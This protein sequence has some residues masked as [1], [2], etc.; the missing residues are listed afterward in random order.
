M[1]VPRLSR[2]TYTVRRIMQL[3]GHEAAKIAY[4]GH[5][6]SA[7][8]FGILFWGDSP[9]CI[10][11]F[12]KQK[13]AI[14]VLCG[15]NGRQ[16]CRELFPKE[17]ILTL[18]GIFIMA[19]VIYVYDHKEILRKN[20]CHHEYETRTR[21]YFTIPYHRKTCAEIDLKINDKE[22][23]KDNV[24]SLLR[25]LEDKGDRLF[26][27]DENIRGII[28]TDGAKDE[29]L[30]EEFD[31]VEFYREE[32]IRQ[33]SKYEVML[34]KIP[35]D[36]AASQEWGS[37]KPKRKFRLPKIELKKFDGNVKNWIGFGGQ[38]RKIHEDKEIDLEDKFQ[39]LLQATEV[40]SGAKEQLRASLSS[41]PQPKNDYEIVVPQ[42]EE[43]NQNE[44]IEVNM[45]EDQ[46][47]V[48]EKMQAE[49]KA[50]AAKELKMR[51]QVIQR[52]FPRPYDVNLSVLRP[53]QE[54]YGLTEMQKAE[55]LI[56]V[57]MTTMMIYD[58]LHNPLL[59]NG[60]KKIPQ[61]DHLLFLDSHQYEHFKE[62]DLEN[63]RVM[64]KGG[65]WRNTEDEILKAA[66]MKYGKN[67]WS[68]IASLLH[69]KSAK[70]CK[71]RW[72]EWLDPSIKKTE[73]SRVEDEK[74]LHLAKLMPTQWRTIA[75]IIGRTAAQ[76]LERYEYLLE[77]A[78]RKEEGE[79][80]NDDP[81]KLKPGETT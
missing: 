58:N 23:N 11:I 32:L 29:D 21:N 38:F 68:R 47:D 6:H 48:D 18:T 35:E 61:K 39:Y 78:Q 50:K 73:W 74:L 69:R 62:E 66:V 27:A 75:P 10:R 43:S 55:E 57:E 22:R 53:P 42:L 63:A 16:S 19:C 8:N 52:N 76:C 80:A 65:V 45:I 44:E 26:A 12:R 41:L 79:Y 28:L 4:F 24:L 2:A 5:F 15:A 71:A 1:L 34:K 60:K 56:K 13:N 36:R 46:A 67:Q 7:L 37:E 3:A 14:R 51:S 31:K 72:F 9:E 33:R 59:A 30:E 20:S 49:L 25:Q 54:M 70:Q 17:G 77:Q 64:I 81:R 40:D